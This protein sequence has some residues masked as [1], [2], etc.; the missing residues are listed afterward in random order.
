MSPEGKLFSEG[1][2][3][4]RIFSWGLESRVKVETGDI[5]EMT[6]DELFDINTLYN[7]YY[8][9]VDDRV[10]VLNHIGSFL[11]PGGF[12]LL[13]TCCQGGGLGTE[14]LNL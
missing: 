9:H 8:F 6:P 4:R 14:A 2:E 5:R 1:V 3:D 7:N 11:K 13:T 12:L 10:T